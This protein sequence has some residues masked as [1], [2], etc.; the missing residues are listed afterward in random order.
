MSNVAGRR[1]GMVKASNGTG[2]VLK[3]RRLEKKRKKK[4][5]RRGVNGR[6]DDRL[7]IL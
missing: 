6:V 4:S 7:C 1:D 5:N 3:K 2:Y